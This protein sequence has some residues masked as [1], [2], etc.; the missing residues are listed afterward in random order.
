MDQGCMK[1]HFEICK[2]FGFKVQ[3]TSD[4]KRQ[5]GTMSL[6]QLPSLRKVK[7]TFFSFLSNQYIFQI[8]ILIKK[9]KK[10]KIGKKSKNNLNQFVSIMFKNLF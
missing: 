6:N 1:H 2:V 3:M 5:S 10:E 9:K 8:N 7:R 4:I